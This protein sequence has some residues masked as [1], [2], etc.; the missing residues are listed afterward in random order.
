MRPATVEENSASLEPFFNPQ[1]VAIIGASAN[2]DKPSG[3]PLV[4]LL[5]S[6]YKGKLF[7]VNPRYQELFGVKCYPSL[8][9]VPEEV[10][11]AIVAVPAA[12][13]LAALRD[14]AVKGVRAAIVITSGFAEVGP[15]GARLQEEL[16]GIARQSGMRICGPNTMGILSFP[17]RLAANFAISVLPEKIS[18]PDFLGFVT[19]S[20]GFGTGIYGMIQ[21]Y[22]IGFSHFISSGN[23]AD[24]D[25][26]EYLAYLVKD[27]HTKVIGGYME[28]IK[29]G[30]GF[31]RAARAALAAGKPVLLI[32]TG[33]FAAAARA[34]ASHTGALVGSD[35]VYDAVF[36]QYGVIR[37]ESFHEMLAV[38]TVLT[39]GKLPRGNR[40]AVVSTSGGAGVFLADKCAES[41]L[42]LTR[43]ASETRAALARVLPPFASVQNP[44]DI[45]SAIMVDPA[46]ILECSRIV[47]QDPGV[48]LMLICHG[49]TEENLEKA[50]RLNFIEEMAL[51]VRDA[52]KPVVNLLWGRQDSAQYMVRA[53]TE[54]RA[55][56]VY[57]I[58]YGVKALAALVRYSAKRQAF[59]AAEA[60][61]EPGS[62]PGRE[63]ARMLEP[64]P[65]PGDVPA[66]GTGPGPGPDRRTG[67]P[68]GRV[69]VPGPGRLPAGAQATTAEILSKYPAG[70]KLTERE[71][72]KVLAAYGVPVTR[73]E[74]AVDAAAAAAAAQRIGFPV[75]LKIES[76]DLLHKTEAGGVKLN[77]Q[78]PAEV[79]AACLEILDN[80][81]RFN[82]AA[83]IEGV[84]V[85]EMLPPGV[86]VIV[87][88]GQD[89]VFG[90]TVVFGLG[91]VLVEALQD[92]AIRVPPLTREDALEMIDEIK[93]RRVL[94]G[95]RG[96][97]PVD[98]EA[99]AEIILK[100]SRLALDFPQI[101]ELDVNPL[102]C[103][104]QGIKAADAL[105]V[106]KE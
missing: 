102:I 54:R 68:P 24:V 30:A 17:S 106:I 39:G 22:G 37:V 81:R 82:P 98:R 97:P 45:T 83:R 18:I 77:L 94:E 58:E 13:V 21:S 14:C 105:I 75:A 99:L 44:I 15:E 20:G 33:R 28:G 60:A 104:P 6:G 93:G 52:A 88:I 95:F 62:E 1:S 69:P 79:E 29:D 103:S 38:L 87:G 19:Q 53:L 47:V 34:A 50:K 78:T 84:L 65:E 8:K 46:L 90:S 91:G 32:K 48:D 3:R 67:L 31:I 71:A 26:S 64:G 23:E 76:P 89:D 96:L 9:D 25:F 2:P 72:K 43:L 73:E 101:A 42:E 92:V 74:L 66:S 4:A 51:F 57:E 5:K 40:L 61:L 63:P 27:S 16:A 55:P 59:Q 41:G 56:A 36:R 85:Q 100:I 12:A 80:V 49:I 86:E 11:L 7:P 10:D 70:A 35:R